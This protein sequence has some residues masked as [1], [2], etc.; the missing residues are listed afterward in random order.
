VAKPADYNEIKARVTRLCSA[1][2]LDL[3][4]FPV[5][6]IGLDLLRV[7]IPAAT[8]GSR[9]LFLAA[10]VHGDE[11]AA[12]TAVLQF[13]EQRRWEQYPEIDFTIY[14]CVNPNGFDAGTRENAAGDDINR[15]FYGEGTPE[16]RAMR[17]SL[18]GARFDYWI[19]AHEDYAEDGYYMF[20]PAD[21]EWA[22]DI[23]RA[24][25]RVGPIN[26]KP[27][28]DEM[29]IVDGIVQFEGDVMERFD[30]REDWPMAFYF[31]KNFSERG[32]TPETP[33]LKPLALR[34]EMQLAAYDAA[35][36]MLSDEA[37]AGVTAASGSA[38]D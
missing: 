30:D 32:F 2:G 34:V 15:S 1:A 16:S 26:I 10:G 24:V 28:I 11:P 9:R 29:D 6:E 23:V 25:S 7:H 38:A 3:Q 22:A 33:G 12:V 5:P 35:L 36:T 13:L 8:A 37:A 17:R 14:P 20:A 27:E 21:S 18:E 31:I 19:D 4:S